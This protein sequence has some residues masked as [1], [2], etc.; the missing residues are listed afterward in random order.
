MEQFE[1]AILLKEL[2]AKTPKKDLDKLFD[3]LLSLEIDGEP[4][5]THDLSY[6]YWDKLGSKCLICGRTDMSNDNLLYAIATNHA[7]ENEIIC[8]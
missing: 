4:I 6:R 7:D 8:K 3:E 2:L 1:S 5:C